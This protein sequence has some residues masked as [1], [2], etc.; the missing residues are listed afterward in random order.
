MYTACT[1][2]MAEAMHLDFLLPVPTY[3]IY[4]A[5]L[6]WAATFLGLI[7]SVIRGL[8]AEQLSDASILSKGAGQGRIM[9]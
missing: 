1:Y 9:T 4:V 3:F 2:E 5:L 7:R 6:A 8:F